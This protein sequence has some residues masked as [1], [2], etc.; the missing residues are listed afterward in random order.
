MAISTLVTAWRSNVKEL[1]TFMKPKRLMQDT[2]TTHYFA[3]KIR[4]R[5]I[6]RCYLL[7]FMWQIDEA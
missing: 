2:A 6:G 1:I 4:S 5:Q 3:D 7:P